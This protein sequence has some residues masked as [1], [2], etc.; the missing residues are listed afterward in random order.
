MRSVHL[1]DDA[2]YLVA[3]LAR[4]HEPTALPPALPSTPVDVDEKIATLVQKYRERSQ[5]LEWN[6]GVERMMDEQNADD[7]DKDDDHPGRSSEVNATEEYRQ[8]RAAGP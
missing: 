3:E 8:T 1:G 7:I 2:P 5:V 4:H 6:E